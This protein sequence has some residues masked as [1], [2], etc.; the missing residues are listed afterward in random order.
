MMSVYITM[1]NTFYKMLH[2]AECSPRNLEG[3]RGHPL[4]QVSQPKNYKQLRP[5][6]ILPTL[7]KVLERF[8]YNQLMSHIEKFGL[9]PTIIIKWISQGL[10]NS[11]FESHR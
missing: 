1:Y 8:L 10:H 3:R 5:I 7:S 4:P 9:V 2:G 11:A 6:G